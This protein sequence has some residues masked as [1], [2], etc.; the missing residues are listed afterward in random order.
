MLNNILKGSPIIRQI[1]LPIEIETN[2][3]ISTFKDA[4]FLLNLGSHLVKVMGSHDGYV[5]AA[6]QVGVNAR[7]MVV[8]T[9]L[10]RADPN[11]DTLNHALI[12]DDSRARIFINPI[13]QPVKGCE[14][15][16]NLEN[17]ASVPN[18]MGIVERYDKISLSAYELKIEGKKEYKLEKVNETL[19]YMD[20]YLTQHCADML[21]GILYIDKIKELFK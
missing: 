13:V 12:E 20:S 1:A 2:G 14:K 21:D 18:L 3:K 6:P 15:H 11:I 10:K 5:I 9:G 17:S 8:Q 16:L 19:R 7:M 4:D